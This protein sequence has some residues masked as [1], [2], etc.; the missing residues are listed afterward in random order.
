MSKHC[1]NGAKLTIKMIEQK[2]PACLQ[3]IFM[4]L[5]GS[6]LVLSPLQAKDEVKVIVVVNGE[7]ITN[8]ELTERTI[9]LRRVAQLQ[10]TEET[11]QRDALQGLIA[12][13]LKMQFGKSIV[14]GIT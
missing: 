13:R 6:F 11:L 2:I 7:P 1:L 9:Y 12:D 5:I 8:L 3:L 14:P 10:M 4:V